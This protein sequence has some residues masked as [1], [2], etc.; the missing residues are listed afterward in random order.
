LIC[1]LTPT[2]AIFQ[3]YRGMK[4]EYENKLHM[5]IYI[6]KVNYQ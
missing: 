1:V 6:L 5:F 4:K 2:L 3:P